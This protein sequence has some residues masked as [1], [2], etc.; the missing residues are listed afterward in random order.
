MEL[1]LIISLNDRP[2]VVDRTSSSSWGVDML[3]REGGRVIGLRSR[4][5]G[6]GGGE[7]NT[8]SSSPLDH[9][10]RRCHHHQR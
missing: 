10:A 8:L 3:G 7:R 6:K 4:Q 1:F 9:H 2:V 5:H